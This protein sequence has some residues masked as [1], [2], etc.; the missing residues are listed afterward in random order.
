MKTA[1]PRPSF[2]KQFSKLGFC[3]LLGR[4]EREGEKGRRE[5]GKREKGK[6]GKREK[7]KKGKEEREMGEKYNE[8]N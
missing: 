6:K 5:K 8:K 3:S 7:G 2:C 4:R 1:S